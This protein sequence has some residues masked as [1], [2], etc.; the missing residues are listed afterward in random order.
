MK[1]Y[2]MGAAAALVLIWAIR[3]ACE[4]KSG[5]QVVA[6]AQAAGSDLGTVTAWDILNGRSEHI[7]NEI[8]PV[9]ERAAMAGYG[10]KAW[11]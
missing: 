3:K 6:T 9:S 8:R 5:A 10:D 11:T 2:M 4:K 7:A 1:R